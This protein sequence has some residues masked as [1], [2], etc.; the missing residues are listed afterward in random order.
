MVPLYLNASSAPASVHLY[1]NIC[2]SSC[3]N[4]IHPPMEMRVKSFDDW[5]QQICSRAYQI[6]IALFMSET[7][8]NQT[9][10]FGS[11]SV[12]N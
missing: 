8:I 7:Y 6:F 10:S 1:I 4:N 3:N 9:F 11:R 12:I 5:T 2:R